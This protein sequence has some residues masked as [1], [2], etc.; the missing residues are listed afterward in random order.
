MVEPINYTAALRRSW[1]LLVV[2]AAVFAIVAV[3]LPVS[4]PP[5]QKDSPTRW[6]ATTIVGAPPSNGIVGTGTVTL[7]QILF[8]GNSFY[9]KAEAATKAKTPGPILTIVGAMSASAQTTK[10]GGGSSTASTSP[11]VKGNAK[12]DT[13]LVQLAAAAAT[14]DEAA[15]LANTYATVLGAKLA[16]VA[17]STNSD[18]TRTTTAGKSATATPAPPTGFQQIIP[19]QASAAKKTTKQPSNLGSSHK[20]R[21][22]AGLVLGLIVGALIVL[23]VELL[24]KRLRT[25]SR[26]EAHF[27]YP[28]VAEVPETWPPPGDEGS[29]RIV[30]VAEPTSRSAE[31]YRKLR[32]SVMFEAMPPAG[33]LPGSAQD[34]YADS[35]LAA[36]AE[37][38]SPPEPG[39]RSVILVAS[40]AGEPSRPRVVANLGATYAESGQRVIIVSTGDIDSGVP[41]GPDVSYTGP[42]HPDDVRAHLR[43]SSIADLSMLSLRPFVR[44]SAQLV[45]RAAD[46]FGAARQVADVVLVEAPPFL[47]FHHGEALAHAVDVVLVVGE[48]GETTFDQADQTGVLLRRIGAPVLGVVFTETPLEK[49]EKRRPKATAGPSAEPDEPDVA[50][51]TDTPEVTGQFPVETQA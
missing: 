6:Q 36:P 15:S 50:V 16:A 8:Y 45:D 37:P 47:E 32:M 28:V 7:G 49:S 4:H 30:V 39:T 26:A 44:N 2:L 40:P 35:L 51:P 48:C 20:V 13:G 38:Y 22:L 25:A 42:V 14:K 31:A 1:R 46:V 29:P 34:P 17:S 11:V 5:S 24:N 3:L 27:R 33:V 9:L 41:P 10:S 23:V 12:N 21:L 19:A 18:T 43:P